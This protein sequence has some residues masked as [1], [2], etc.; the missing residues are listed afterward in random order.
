VKGARIQRPLWASTGTKDPAYRDVYYVEPL[1]GRDTVNT[2]PEQTIRAF[3]DHGEV[4]AN[5]IEQGVEQAARTIQDLSDAGI[6]L[7]SVA[8]QLE[9]EGIRQF[10]EAFDAAHRALEEKRQ[11]AV[12]KPAAA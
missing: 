7:H 5:Q 6:D 4:K 11:Q 1:I 12:R 8:W 2:M 3:A 10:N 9:H